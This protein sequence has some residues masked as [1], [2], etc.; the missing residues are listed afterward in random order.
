MRRRNKDFCL[1]LDKLSGV[2]GV[3]AHK[4]LDEVD[5][6][7]DTAYTAYEGHNDSEDTL[8][9]FAKK[10]VVDTESTEEEAKKS[11]HKLVFAIYVIFA[12]VIVNCNTA[13][14]SNGCVGI[15]RLATVGAVCVTL[16]NLNTALK[17]D[18]LIIVHL[19]ATVSTIHRKSPLD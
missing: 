14:K 15:N 7:N 4:N 2:N 13:V 9:I 16:S 3:L 6:R 11:H 12:R 8:L 10:E 5:K 1:K 17:T 18:G 19:F